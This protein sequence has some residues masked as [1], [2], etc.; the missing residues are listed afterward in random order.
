[1]AP[2]GRPGAF[3]RV[4]A[5]LAEALR[6]LPDE[7]ALADERQR[8][9]ERCE[10]LERL[11]GRHEEF[12]AQSRAAWFFSGEED[13]PGSRRACERALTSFS[14]LQREDWWSRRPAADLNAP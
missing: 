9:R 4:A 10:R 13:P 2:F 6:A 1:E 12:L 11:A 5:A 8:L 7:P 14:V 3:T